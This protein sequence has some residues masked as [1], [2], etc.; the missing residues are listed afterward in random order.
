MSIKE[1]LGCLNATRQ[2]RKKKMFSKN[3][4]SLDIDDFRSKVWISIEI[5]GCS[6]QGKKQFPIHLI[7]IEIL[8]DVPV[9]ALDKI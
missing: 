3:N 9:P 6:F 7:I 2:Y 1:I 5:T 4:L 8:K